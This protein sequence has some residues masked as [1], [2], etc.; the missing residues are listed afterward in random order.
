VRFEKVFKMSD[1]IISMDISARNLPELS[2]CFFFTTIDPFFRIFR[3][4]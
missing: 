3:R 4:R 2:F 1:Q